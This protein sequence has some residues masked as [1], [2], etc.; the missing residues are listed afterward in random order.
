MVDDR[1]ARMTRL[2]DRL[3]STTLSKSEREILE[4]RLAE[5]QSQEVQRT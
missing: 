3:D 5:L 4:Q 2:Q 1:E